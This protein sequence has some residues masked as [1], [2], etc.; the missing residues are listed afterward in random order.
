MQVSTL[1]NSDLQI[2]KI[3]LG[4]WAIGGG[5]AKVGWGPQDEKESIA[6]IL[7]ALELGINW[8]DTAPAYGLGRSEEVIGKAIKE[9]GEPVLLATKCGIQ[10]TADKGLERDLRP[11]LIEKELDASL[12][13]LG[14]DCIDLYQIHW[15]VPD[16][17]IEAAYEAI[18]EQKK[19]GKIRW[20]GVSNFSAS[21]LQRVAEIEVPSSL[22]PPYSLLDRR[23][24]DD[25]LPWCKE[26]GVGVIAY[27]PMEC[28]LLT[29]KLSQDWVESLPE[30]DWRKSSWARVKPINYFA[31]PELSALIAWIAELQEIC[32]GAPAGQI[33]INWVLAQEGVSAAIVGA[34]RPQQIEETVKAASW[35]LSKTQLEEISKSFARY[36]NQMGR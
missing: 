18:L 10:E 21:Q 16:E 15:P 30:S 13:R 11:E 28:G 1:G 14:V 29:G 5:E 31:E 36:Q 33:A 23:I 27:S 17:N 24:E 7:K 26:Q 35:E 2:S 34:R 22:Q 8:I 19:K 32:D 4:T 25:S 20:L 12:S 9:F 3:G 6:C